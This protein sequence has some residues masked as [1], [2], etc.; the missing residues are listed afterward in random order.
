VHILARA[1]Q[2]HVAPTLL[3]REQTVRIGSKADIA[4]DNDGWGE[5]VLILRLFAHVRA[6]L[7]LL[8]SLERANRFV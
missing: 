8:C 6:C 5:R 3:G 7:F 4:A 1:P 2:H